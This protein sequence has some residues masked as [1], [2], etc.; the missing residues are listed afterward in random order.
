MSSLSTSEKTTV[1][2][3]PACHSLPADSGGYFEPECHIQTAQGIWDKQRRQI[4]TPT[5]HQYF[6]YL[7]YLYPLHW[8]NMTL[9]EEIDS[10]GNML[11][12]QLDARALY[13][14]IWY[15]VL[16]LQKCSSS[17]WQECWIPGF[18][19]PKRF[20]HQI[21]CNLFWAS[22][23]STLFDVAPPNTT[24][25]CAL[26]TQE[27]TLRKE[28]QPP[29]LDLWKAG[30]QDVEKK[31]SKR[32]QNPASRNGMLRYTLTM[33][34]WLMCDVSF[35]DVDCREHR[36]EEVTQDISGSYHKATEVQR[37]CFPEVPLRVLEQKIVLNDVE[38][39][40]AHGWKATSEH[41]LYHS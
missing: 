22:R 7:A 23:G 1:F 36:V 34:N 17:C 4:R 9:R 12:T 32:D 20:C 38:N 13:M 19:T 6:Q 14:D 5:G 2:N 10:L 25:L 26:W 8:Y 24:Y 27:A 3:V 35:L 31:T 30:V 33:F 21:P 15:M 28:T 29:P 18:Q 40:L 16:Y 41:K 39:T 11:D 37:T